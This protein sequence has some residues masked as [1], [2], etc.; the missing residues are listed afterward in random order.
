[1][2]L[3]GA[4][5]SGNRTLWDILL[6][7]KISYFLHDIHTLTQDILLRRISWGYPKISC[8]PR[9]LAQMQDILLSMI[10]CFWP[11]YLARQDILVE[12]KISRLLDILIWGKISSLPRY[13]GF[14]NQ[15]I[16][17][18]QDILLRRLDTLPPR[19]LGPLLGHDQ[20]ILIGSRYL[21]LGQDILLCV[22]WIWTNGLQSFLKQIKAS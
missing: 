13:L 4:V 10:T 22:H 14:P 18:Y 21:A 16:L 2:S 1:M 12:S 5:S 3:C 17:L 8:P 11:R 9:Y 20:D 15:D 6:V 7:P 19:Y